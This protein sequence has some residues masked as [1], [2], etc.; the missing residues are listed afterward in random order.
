MTLS[1]LYLSSY[2]F[3][4][5]P[6]MKADTYYSTFIVFIHSPSHS[7]SSTVQYSNIKYTTCKSFFERHLLA[8]W[9]TLYLAL[10]SGQCIFLP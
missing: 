2:I 3:K 7:L 10:H 4:S 1:G 6:E 9:V 5:Y 8:P